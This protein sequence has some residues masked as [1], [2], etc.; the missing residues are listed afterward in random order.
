MQLA[1]IN[2]TTGNTVREVEETPTV[3]QAS[4]IVINPQTQR[5]DVAQRRIFPLATPVPAVRTLIADL[6]ARLKAVEDAQKNQK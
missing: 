2:V 1:V 3:L 4:E 5:Y 6:D